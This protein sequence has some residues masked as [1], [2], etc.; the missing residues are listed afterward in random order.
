MYCIKMD[1]NFV[2]PCER[3]MAAQVIQCLVYVYVLNVWVEI[4]VSTF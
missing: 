1:I 3:D 2:K 4:I